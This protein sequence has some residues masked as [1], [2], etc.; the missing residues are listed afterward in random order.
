MLIYRIQ[1]EI[2]RYTLRRM[3]QAKRGTLSRSVLTSI[4]GI[5]ESKAKK[6]LSA[7]GGLAGVKRADLAA[8][9]AVKGISKKDAEAVYRRYHQNQTGESAI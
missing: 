6:L 7:F 3:E 4:P 1:E 9:Y 8:L 2:H 5:G